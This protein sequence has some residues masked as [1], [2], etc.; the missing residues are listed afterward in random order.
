MNTDK[1]IT[2]VF[3]STV[4][5][6]C[7]GDPVELES[8]IFKNGRDCEC[9]ALTFIKIGPNVAIKD[10]ANI[11]FTAPRIEVKPGTVIEPGAVVNM[12]QE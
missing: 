4:C 6:E 5:P 8:V 2:A 1:N 3:S 12:R 10:G 9:S 7:S 11:T